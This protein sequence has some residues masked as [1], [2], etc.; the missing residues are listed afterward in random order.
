MKNKEHL[1]P[2]GLQKILDIRASINN[3]ITNSIQTNFPNT[4]AVSK[5]LVEKR[6]PHDD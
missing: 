4:K 1:T 3:G 6:I 2:G 5:P